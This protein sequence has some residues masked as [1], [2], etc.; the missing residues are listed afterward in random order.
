M[1]KSCIY[2]S[3]KD[4]CEKYRELLSKA[5]AEALRDLKYCIEN[6]ILNK[7]EVKRFR[8]SF[9][10]QSYHKLC[11]EYAYSCR[12]GDQALS[13]KERRRKELIAKHKSLLSFCQAVG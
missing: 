5:K 1:V 12:N 10:A 2:C 3:R 9:F 11:Q 13:P 7:D 8:A 6:N 4:E